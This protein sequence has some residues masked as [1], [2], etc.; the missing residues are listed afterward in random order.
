MLIVI[1]HGK[2][3]L[4]EDGSEKLRGWLPV[5][6]T[7]EGM[8]HSKETAFHLEGLE[9]VKD[10]YTSDLVRAVQSAQ[11]VAQVLQM[12]L[13]PKEELRDWNYGHLTGI[14]VNNSTLNQLFDYMDNPKKKVP[15]GEPF[16]SFLD[17]TVPF[18]HELVEDDDLQVVVTH[19]RVC[20]LL[21][22]IVE[23]KGKSPN[24]SVLKD[25]GP[26][27]PSGVMIITPDWTISYKTPLDEEANSGPVKPA[28]YD[29]KNSPDLHAI[30]KLMKVKS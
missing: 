24:M 22:A 20:T 16:Q 30:K 28:K 7:L 1:R 5:P 18:L 26:I 15:D 11:E 27:D 9:D 4:N 2:T 8:D 29:S 13:E 6:L 23:S 3:A 25:K 14:E 17:R 19:N 12:E 21:N 10:L